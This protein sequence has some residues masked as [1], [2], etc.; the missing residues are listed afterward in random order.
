[1]TD[2][3]PEG[4][5][6][7][8][9]GQLRD[10]DLTFPE[11]ARIAAESGASVFLS[12]W[13]RRGAKTGG[14]ANLSQFF[15]MFG[16]EAGFAL[17]R[18]LGYR[19][20]ESFPDFAARATAGAG[21]VEPGQLRGWFPGVTLDIEDEALDLDFAGSHSDNNSLRM[22]YKLWRAVGLKRAEEKRRGRRFAAVVLF[23]PDVLPPEPAQM[24][25]P[26]ALPEAIFLP[27]G[28]WGPRH[29]HDVLIVCSSE[30]ADAIGALFGRA[31]LERVSG[32][33]GIHPQLHDHLASLGKEIRSVPVPLALRERAERHQPRN[34][35][36]LR[37]LLD[38]GNW[39]AQGWSKP[40]PPLGKA[41]ADLLHAVEEV[42]DGKPE[43]ALERL[44]ALLHREPPLA[45]LEGVASVA[46]DAL[47]AQGRKRDAYALL[48]MRVLAALVPEPGWLEDGE[49]H[50]NLTR[51]SE[52][53]GALTGQQGSCAAI[54]ALL[55]EALTAPVVREVW[56]ALL[57]L[58]PWDRLSAEAER[59]AGFFGHD[60]A[61]MSR[62]F[63][64]LLNSNRLDEAA[65]LA[66]RMRQS[67]PGDWRGNDHLGHVHSRR[68]EIREAL[69][70]AIAALAMEPENW[71]LLARVGKLHEQLGQLPQARRHM[72][73]ALARNADHHVRAGYA[74]LLARMGETE[75][76]RRYVSRCLAEAPEDAW[77]RDALGPL[78]PQAA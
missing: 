44:R 62:R 60:I 55:D 61:V 48:L 47:L 24:P 3:Q 45:V 35:A 49:F 54:E 33:D 17:P 13:R 32:W 9:Y 25:P 68:G 6:F 11:T 56:T 14:A 21:E 30:T 2:S 78:V 52:A 75:E 40:K 7:C 42:L 51:L 26:A 39:D 72:E 5:A 1:M 53:G 46:A 66:A 43:A 15:R 69:D 34:R 31:V 38:S 41:L 63:W 20:S 71:G 65:A 29:A 59:V 28:G 57:R 19:F 50:R 22:L 23:R 18:R 37:E 27:P 4:T 77:L 74:H 36:L 70:C 8:I 73:A 67:A 76:M 10:E 58:L 64:Q 12:T 16:R